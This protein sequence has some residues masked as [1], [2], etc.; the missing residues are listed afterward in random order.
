VL[1]IRAALPLYR[2]QW[3]NDASQ[4]VGGQSKEIVMPREDVPDRCHLNRCV[5]RDLEAREKRAKPI[6][7]CVLTSMLFCVMN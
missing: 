7:H 6:A 2:D 4:Y 5:V 3:R 1:P